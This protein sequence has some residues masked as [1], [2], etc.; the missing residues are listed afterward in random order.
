MVRGVGPGL[1]K[2]SPN[3]AGQ[4]LADP[5]LTLNELQTIGGVAQFVPVATNDNWGGSDELRATMNAL[6]S[7]GIIDFVLTPR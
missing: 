6:P 3:L 1:L 2:D 7:Q 4:E 5:V